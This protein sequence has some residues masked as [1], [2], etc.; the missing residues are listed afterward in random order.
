MRG[1]ECGAREG[2]D[3]SYCL[4]AAFGKHTISF[5]PSPRLAYIYR[6][7]HFLKN[8]LNPPLSNAS[9]LRYW[10]SLTTE[11]KKRSQDYININR[12]TNGN[13]RFRTTSTRHHQVDCPKGSMKFSSG[14]L[15]GCIF[16]HQSV[17]IKNSPPPLSLSLL[18]SF[19]IVSAPEAPDRG[20]IPTLFDHWDIQLLLPVGIVVCN[21]VNHLPVFFYIHTNVFAVYDTS[22]VWII[23]IAV[24]LAWPFRSVERTR[25][26]FDYFSL[27]YTKRRGDTAGRQWFFLRTVSGARLL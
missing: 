3:K 14:S 5:R 9:P 6:G 16:P 15:D 8:R 13:E 19:F 17:F 2:R 22:F 24:T 18:D 20:V 26:S 4:R 1:D 23:Q 11:E 21:A 27:S 7:K 12:R 10:R 25:T